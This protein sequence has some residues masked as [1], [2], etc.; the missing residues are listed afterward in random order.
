M[1]WYADAT[2][3]FCRN[4]VRVRVNTVDPRSILMR[5]KETGT[6]EDESP[7]LLLENI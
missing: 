4:E 7:D 5:G 2:K 6:P 1:T 3:C